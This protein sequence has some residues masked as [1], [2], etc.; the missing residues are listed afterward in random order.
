MAATQYRGLDVLDAEPS[1]DSPATR[2]TRD[3]FRFD[4]G[5]GKVVV[6]DRSGVAVAE[7]QAFH[8]IM[9]GRA[10]IQQ[11]RD[12]VAARRGRAVPC[13]LPSWRRDFA[14]VSDLLAGASSLV[15]QRVGYTRQAFPFSARR[16]LAV[17]LPNRT[18]FYR[19]VTA[20]SEASA[21]ETLT[22]DSALPVAV[23]ASAM[24]C[25]LVLVRLDAD[26]PQLTWRT[27][28]VA[29]AALGFVELP[30]EVPV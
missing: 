12:F 29:E 9:E 5:L 14:L 17:I 18:Q 4:P 26:D 24:V 6:K 19:K 2:W 10:E 21:T 23:A 7:P 15:I 25:Q 28:D 3:L 8:W 27:R 1:F 30:I 16:H 20:A 11:Y 13:W 22:I